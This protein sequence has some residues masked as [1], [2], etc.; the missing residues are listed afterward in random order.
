M[1]NPAYSLVLLSTVTALLVAPITQT[2]AQVDEKVVSFTDIRRGDPH[3]GI[4]PFGRLAQGLD[5]NFYGTTYAAQGFGGWAASNLSEFPGLLQLPGA[6]PDFDGLINLVEFA[7]NLKPGLSDQKQFEDPL[8]LSEE[9]SGL[10]RIELVSGKLQITSLRRK[11]A[12]E[13]G[14]SY[15]YEFSSDAVNWQEGF[16]FPFP[17]AGNSEWELSIAIDPVPAGLSRRLARV[18]I[19]QTQ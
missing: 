2:S 14:L 15:H 17:I 18:R 3:Q 1:A 10:P 12:A 16:A 13:L 11:N 19:Q 9:P 8:P 4:Q 7:F 5:G 6:D